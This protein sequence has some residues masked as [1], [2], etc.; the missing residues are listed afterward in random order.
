MKVPLGR[1]LARL[2][3]LALTTT[4]AAAAEPLEECDAPIDDEL[5]PADAAARALGRGL[6]VALHEMRPIVATQLAATW[7]LSPD[8]VR[9]LALGLALEW[10]FR[11]VGDS[12]VIDHLSRDVDPAIRIAA[13][14]AAWTRRATGG[15]AGVLERLAED[16]DPEV[17]AVARIGVL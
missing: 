6:A 2:T 13:A 7:S 10:S 3:A 17:R 14:R 11:L 15:D 16:P 1:L 9:R 5:L 12:L 4:P 8:P